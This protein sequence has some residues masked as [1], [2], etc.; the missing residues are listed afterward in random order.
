MKKLLLA[1]TC[2]SAVMGGAAFAADLPS[3]KAPPPIYTSPAPVFSWTGFYIGAN[4]GYGWMDAFN[5]GVVFAPGG[6]ADPH[7]GIV[8]GG[9]I[10]YNYQFSPMFVA[11]LETDFQGSGVGGGIT[12][13]KTPWFGTVRARLGVTPFAAPVMLY[14]TGGFAYG[15]LNIGPFF[16]T[17][18][19]FGKVATGWTAGA[20]VE[21]AFT[22]NWSAKVEYL[23]TNLGANYPVGV[24][25]SDV[26]QRVHDHL[27]RVGL[28]YRFGWGASPVVAKY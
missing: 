23:F 10:G 21:Y 28:N 17:G 16:P 1:A 5:K 25:G 20:G 26:Q 24:F 22:P 8:G 13:R 2:F 11:G 14:A 19:S 15:R 12:A 3:R 7:G 9:Q 27:V 18:V 6:L 4:V